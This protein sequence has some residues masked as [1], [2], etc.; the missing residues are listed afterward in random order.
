MTDVAVT[1]IVADMDVMVGVMGETVATAVTEE[2]M[3]AMVAT[4]VEVADME[5]EVEDVDSEV[6]GADVVVVAG[7]VVV[8]V[9]EVVQLLARRH[10]NLSTSPIMMR[11]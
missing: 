5:V 10:L 3:D 2:A 4:D 8:A 1:T 11:I 6:V 9:V 7:A